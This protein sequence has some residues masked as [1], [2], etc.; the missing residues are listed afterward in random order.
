MH[1]SVPVRR[2][3]RLGNVYRESRCGSRLA[4]ASIDSRAQRVPRDQ[5]HHQKDEWPFL[6]HFVNGENS[7]MVQRRRSSRLLQ[8]PCPKVPRSCVAVRQHLHR[9]RT[10]QPLI[11]RAVDH[12]H[13]AAADFRLNPIV[14]DAASDHFAGSGLLKLCP[15][16]S[17]VNVRQA[18]TRADC[19]I[20]S[21]GRPPGPAARPSA[22]ATRRTP[23][24]CRRKHRTPPTPPRW[25]PP[26]ASRAPRPQSA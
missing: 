6:A 19:I 4:R 8:N 24:Q 21:G 12:T 14:R 3:Q 1:A 22:R 23:A 17:D 7:R 18:R 15:A 11:V 5:F 9:H 20:R 26:R 10:I 13:A 2:F 25:A 16:A